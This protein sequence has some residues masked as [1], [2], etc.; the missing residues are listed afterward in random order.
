M[1]FPKSIHELSGPVHLAYFATRVLLF[2][3]L[4]MPASISA[5][6]NPQSSLRRYFGAAIEQVGAFLAY[7]DEIE[8]NTLRAFWGRRRCSERSVL[9][10]LTKSDGRSQLILISNFLVYLFLL[11]SGPEQVR[12]TFR[13]LELFHASLQR[14]GNLVN[15]ESLS[16]VRPA[17]LRI[18]SFFTQ[19]AQTMRKGVA[20]S[21]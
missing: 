4:L 17:F 21:S 9:A 5:K 19:A 16:L 18:D 6:G 3:A 7:M 8:L 12:A 2:R 13:L 20:K 14:I 10:R 1:F 11:S 15:E